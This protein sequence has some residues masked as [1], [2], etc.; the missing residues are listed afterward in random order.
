MRT[1]VREEIATGLEANLKPI[2]DNLSKIQL[3]VTSC[4][5]KVDPLEAAA[6]EDETKRSKL[7]L[8][9]KM[10]ATEVSLLKQKPKLLENQSRKLNLRILGLP[11]ETEQGRPTSFVN[12]ML[13][14]LFGQAD[15]GPLPP[16]NITHLH[17]R[18]GQGLTLHDYMA[19]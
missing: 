3:K 18:Q 2:K 6:N 1:I 17:R 16:A 5:E 12:D 10:L 15:L 13:R 7:E 19:V 8:E 4:L 14:E 11:G 9:N